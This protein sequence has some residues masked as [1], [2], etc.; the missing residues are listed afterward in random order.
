MRL[1][2]P[3]SV[4]LCACMVTLSC[5]AMALLGHARNRPLGDCWRTGT[6]RSFDTSDN[7]ERS[8]PK[9][10]ED[11]PC[12]PPSGP[13]TNVLGAATVPRPS[14]DM[15]G[16]GVTNTTHADLGSGAT[17]G[18]KRWRYAPNAEKSI[19]MPCSCRVRHR[20]EPN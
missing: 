17:C 7:E 20:T 6:N 10:P 11:V 5:V 4:T 3:C 14:P 1:F 2:M 8:E 13:V 16:G 19:L 9:N 18:M 15:P 12:G